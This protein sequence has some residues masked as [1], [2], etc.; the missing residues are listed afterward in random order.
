MGAIFDRKDKKYLKG[1]KFL[2]KRHKKGDF[3]LI[4]TAKDAKIATSIGLKHA[5]IS[6]YSF[7]VFLP[8][9]WSKLPCCLPFFLSFLKDQLCLILKWQTIETGFSIIKGPQIKRNHQLRN[10]TWAYSTLTEAQKKLKHT[11]NLFR[12]NLQL[13]VV[14]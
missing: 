7:Q 6:H 4:L 8:K 10:S 14:C 13:K 2:P 1:G 11:G 9:M 3:S 12:K 5:L